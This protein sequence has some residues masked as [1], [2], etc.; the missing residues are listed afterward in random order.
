MQYK[1]KTVEEMLFRVQLF[2][3]SLINQWLLL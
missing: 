2:E 1:E 3:I